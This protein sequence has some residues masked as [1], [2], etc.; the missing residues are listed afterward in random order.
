MHE[1]LLAEARPALVCTL[2]LALGVLS[3]KAIVING[4]YILGP[5]DQIAKAA[6]CRIFEGDGPRIFTQ[7]SFDVIPVVDVKGEPAHQATCQSDKCQEQ[8]LSKCANMS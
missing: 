8:A 7:H 4:K 6:A 3:H 5:G 1:M 2:T